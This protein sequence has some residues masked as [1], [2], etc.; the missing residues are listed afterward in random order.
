MSRGLTAVEEPG[1]GNDIMSGI[2]NP[3]AEPGL[4]NPFVY[5]LW[6]RGGRPDSAVI[7]ALFARLGDDISLSHS[8]ANGTAASLLVTSG[9]YAFEILGLAQDSTSGT[10]EPGVR[11]DLSEDWR[12][13]TEPVVLAP[14]SALAEGDEPLAV[15]RS[16]SRIALALV[17]AGDCVGIGWA[18]AGSVMSA[19]FF[20]RVVGE[21]LSGGPFPALGL[22]AIVMEADEALVSRGL[23]PICGQEVCVPTGAELAPAQRARVAIRM[24]DYMA[25]HGPILEEGEVEIDGFGAFAVALSVDSKKIYLTR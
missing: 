24:I 3:G 7:D 17:S 12:S 11:F 21:W 20:D 1:R 9:D 19:A 23:M 15:I 22:T 5:T 14:Q 16:A 8:P 4:A 10:P 13:G 25:A 18:A 2:H 6:F